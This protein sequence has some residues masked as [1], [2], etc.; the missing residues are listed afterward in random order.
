MVR[1]CGHGRDDGALLS[2]TLGTGGDEDADVL[3]P[4]T[5]GRPL[6]AGGVPEGL[7]LSGE[8]SVTSWDTEEEGI[9]LL[10]GVGVDD[11]DL[12]GLWRSVHLGKD[13]LWESL[14]DPVRKQ[15]VLHR[16]NPLTH[17]VKK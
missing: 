8:V 16:G 11:G 4:V 12:G 9:V 15:S 3:A 14:G 10:E 17:G 6:L 7:P 1:K 13:I 5:A 2:T